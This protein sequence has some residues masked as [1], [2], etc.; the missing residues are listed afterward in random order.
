[1]KFRRLTNLELQKV[2]KEFIQFLAANSI[3]AQEW[4]ELKV[5]Q[6]HKAE[7]LIEM[8]SDIV[9]E[10]ALSKCECLEKVA[11]FE[12]RTYKFFEHFVKLI[13][14]KIQPTE[15]IDFTKGKLGPTLQKVVKHHANDMEVFHAKKEYK[16]LR[17][18]EMFEVLKTG[19][20]MTDDRLFSKLNTLLPD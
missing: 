9:I 14:I 16:K 8:F 4:E 15:S 19:A 12:F 7:L 11:P 2:E 13:V 10:K 17:E 5:N 1:M 3:T 18:Q 6:E 20:Y